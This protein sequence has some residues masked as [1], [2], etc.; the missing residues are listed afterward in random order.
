M[1]N[2]MPPGATQGI[3]AGKE[4]AGHIPAAVGV[5][6]GGSGLDGVT[7]LNIGAVAPCDET[8]APVKQGKHLFGTFSD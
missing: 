1:A 3:A 8:A 2:K 6:A 5:A 7:A 4:F